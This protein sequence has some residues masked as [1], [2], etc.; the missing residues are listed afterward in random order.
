MKEIALLVLVGEIIIICVLH[1]IK[2]DPSSEAAPPA[3]DKN[4]P[5]AVPKPDSS[6]IAFR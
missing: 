3:I 5:V 6:S 4:I 2:S 1:A